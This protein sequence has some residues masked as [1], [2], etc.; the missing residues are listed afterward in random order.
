MAVA[1]LSLVGQEGA[2]SSPVVSA[3]AY[4]TGDF[5]VETVDGMRRFPDGSYLVTPT[6]LRNLTRR[7]PGQ[8]GE[9]MRPLQR[10]QW[11]QQERFAAPWTENEER[12][13]VNLDAEPRTPVVK[14]AIL[15]VERALTLTGSFMFR[16]KLLVGVSGASAT[17][18][19]DAANLQQVSLPALTVSIALQATAIGQGQAFSSPSD[20][21]KAVAFF[22]DGVTATAPAKWTERFFVAAGITQTCGVPAGGT[23]FRILGEDGV[24][25]SPFTA[26]TVYIPFASFGQT[27]VFTGLQL[28][29]NRTQFVPATGHVRSLAINN[30]LNANAIVGLIEWEIDL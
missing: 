24:A 20:S 11:G 13:L 2:S 23:R 17:F 12:I 5:P 26:A 27:D 25:S 19:I 21:V 22:A 10:Q 1:A 28:G 7:R 30:T 29:A 18:V 4:V 16:W 8:M 6:E 15:G 9:I 3:G 14:T